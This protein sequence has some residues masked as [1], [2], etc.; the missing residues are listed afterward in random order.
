M[1]R[2]GRR[3]DTTPSL[4]KPVLQA[5]DGTFFG[6]SDQGMVRFDQSGKI[7]WNVGDSPQLA[8]ADNGVVGISGTTYDANGNVTGQTSLAIPS[9]TGETSYEYGSVDE[10]INTQPPP[11]TPP[12]ASFPGLNR[13]NTGVS[14]P[15]RDDRDQ[16]MPEYVTFQSEFVPSCQEFDD[17]ETFGHDE[18]YPFSAFTFSVMNQSDIKRN[19]HPNWALL[20]LSMLKPVQFISD[21]YAS[22]YDQELTVDSAYRSPFVQYEVTKEVCAQIGEN[23]CQQHPR[24]RHIHG[25]AIDFNTYHDKQTWDTLHDLIRD[26]V[27]PNA[28]IEPTTAYGHL[29]ADWRPWNQC[30]KDWQQ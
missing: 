1:L 13:S 8:T 12:Y 24:D 6:T 10:V 9:W 26:T 16:L 27:S 14:P 22:I 3:V 4:L 7:K 11:A 29:H 19:D 15:C 25:D 20:R 18:L 28:C 23:P 21:D 5:Q 17:A 30:R 2:T